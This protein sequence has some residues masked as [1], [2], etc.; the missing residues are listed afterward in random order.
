MAMTSAQGASFLTTIEMRSLLHERAGETGSSTPPM[1]VLV[2]EEDVLSLAVSASH[3]QD[4]E[5]DQVSVI[6]E[7]GS[8]SSTRS[9]LSE[10]ADCLMQA[11]L[12]AA[13]ELLQLDAVAYS[14]LSQPLRVPSSGADGPLP[15]FL[16]PL[17]ETRGLHAC[18]R[19]TGGV[20]RISP[21]GRALAGMHEAGLERMPNVE[22]TI[23]SLI[24]S[25]E[26]A[27]QP[28]VRCPNGR[29]AQK[30]L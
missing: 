5:G 17:Q 7:M 22:P 16:F 4:D 2:P 26:E 18:W 21:D 3:F 10:A 23:A 19:N 30:G 29:S 28:T 12:R 11:I 1:P 27:L 20:S 6:S 13:L 15:L 8:L 24:V 14:R 25:L 9:S